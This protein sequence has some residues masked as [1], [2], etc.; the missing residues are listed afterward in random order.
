MSSV[1][2][3]A[4]A[5]L[6]LIQNEQGSEIVKPL[7]QFASMSTVNITEVLTFLHRTE[8]VSNDEAFTLVTE[9]IPYIIPFDLEQAAYTA[10][11]QQYTKLKGLSLGDRAYIT[12]GIKLQVPIYTADKIWETLK[13]NNADIKL[14]R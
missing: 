11:L 6:A 10:Q 8:K 7:V 13:L 3:Y 2:L 4:S 1:V 14:I 5:L 9:V 12:L